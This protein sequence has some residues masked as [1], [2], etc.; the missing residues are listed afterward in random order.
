[1]KEMFLPA[2]KMLK[3]DGK[4]LLVTPHGSW[5]RGEVIY[6]LKVIYYHQISILD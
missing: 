4:F 3:E 5:M 6:L 2:K 1:V